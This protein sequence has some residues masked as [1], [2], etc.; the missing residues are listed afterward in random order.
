MIN[1]VLLFSTVFQGAILQKINHGCT[2]YK[3]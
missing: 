3:T 1:Y 2:K